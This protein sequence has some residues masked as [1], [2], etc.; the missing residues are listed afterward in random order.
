MCIPICEHVQRHVSSCVCAHTRA[1][2]HIRTTVSSQHTCW[3]FQTLSCVRNLWIGKNK[4]TAIRGL[5]HMTRLERLDLK[6]NRCGPP[7]RP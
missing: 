3:L 5:D 6:S 1:D 7:G 2:R 4:I